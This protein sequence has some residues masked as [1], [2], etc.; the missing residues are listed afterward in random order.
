[1]QN[2]IRMQNKL[3]VC[4]TVDFILLY[5]E[6]YSVYITRVSCTCIYIG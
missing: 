4:G 6:L 5:G 1:M 3:K 2:N